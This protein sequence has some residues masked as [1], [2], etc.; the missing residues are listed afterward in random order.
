MFSDARRSLELLP[1]NCKL[2]K[3][4]QAGI[5]RPTCVLERLRKI[6]CS[7]QKVCSRDAQDFKEVARFLAL[8]D[9]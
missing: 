6:T 3:K 1:T 4:L 5:N 7:L 9:P 8:I 2:L